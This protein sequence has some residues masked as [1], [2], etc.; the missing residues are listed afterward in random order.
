[1][2]GKENVSGVKDIKKNPM[3]NSGINFGGKRR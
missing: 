3:I 1:M 2:G